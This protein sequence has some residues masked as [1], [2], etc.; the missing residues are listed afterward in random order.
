ML[1]ANINPELFFS[2]DTCVSKAEPIIHDK[3]NISV[4]RCYDVLL[5]S[6]IETITNPFEIKSISCDVNFQLGSSK[7]LNR[8]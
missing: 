2:K 3:E 6:I 8:I 5:K 4:V 7:F 1:R